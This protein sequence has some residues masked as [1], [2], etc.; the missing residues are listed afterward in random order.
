M[1]IS[2]FFNIIYNI[3]F[4]FV[5]FI[6][7]FYIILKIITIIITKDYLFSN[8]NLF[9]IFIIINIVISTLLIKRVISLFLRYF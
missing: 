4:Q 5:T 7:I 1:K 3:I 2:K 6:S 9:A 8:T